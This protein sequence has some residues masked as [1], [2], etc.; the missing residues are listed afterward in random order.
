MTSHVLEDHVR[1]HVMTSH[2]LEDHVLLEKKIHTELT[3]SLSLISLGRASN[4]MSNPFMEE[5]LI[6]PRGCMERML[7]REERRALKIGQHRLLPKKKKTYIPGFPLN[8][9]NKASNSS[10]NYG[11]SKDLQ[12]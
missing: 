7:E 1:H 8:S 2:V 12:Q 6:R 10:S 5:F 9:T 4:I 3:A 11:V